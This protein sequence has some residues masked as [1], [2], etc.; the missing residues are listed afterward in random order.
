MKRTRWLLVMVSALLVMGLTGCG[1]TKAPS[2]CDS[3][4]AG[5]SHLCII[6]AK[7]G[8]RLEDIGNTLIVAN[9]VAIGSGAYSQEQARQ[10]LL[11][12]RATLN[13][14]V[15]YLAMQSEVRQALT[16]YPG[17]FIVATVVLDQ[18]GVDQVIGPV[19]SGILKTWLDRQIDTLPATPA[20][21]Q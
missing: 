3:I 15:S 20:R 17:L 2:V 1:Q 5:S 14:P 9:A 13:G 16:K 7:T 12:L 4:P 6:A 11:G 18:M 21:Q 19:D 8:M 10:V